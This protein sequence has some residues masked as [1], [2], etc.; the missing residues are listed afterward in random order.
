M[1]NQ[2]TLHAALAKAQAEMKNAPLNK[3]NP[4]FKSKY[5]DLA[6]IRDSVIPALTANG[7]AVTQTPEFHDGNWVLV[8]TLRHSG[9]SFID[10]AYP[11]TI[12]K[13][14]AMG[15]QL[16]YARRYAL[17]A[18][19]C[20]SAD[21]DDDANAAQETAKPVRQNTVRQPEDAKEITEGA[22]QWVQDQLDH[23]ATF[24]MVSDLEEWLDK[25]ATS[26]GIAKL[27]KQEPALHTTLTHGIAMVRNGLMKLEN[28]A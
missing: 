19:C 18:M 1:N 28:V 8:T 20:I 22:R 2:D 13:P 15:S 5:A 12:D 9:G 4:H 14:Q 3:V 27:E 6:S 17:A 11:L 10:S 7:I 16:T 25:S 23:I 21:E 24:E 26:K